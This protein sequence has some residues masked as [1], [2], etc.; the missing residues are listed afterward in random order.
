MR[1]YSHSYAEML[2]VNGTQISYSRVE[3]ATPGSGKVVYS[4]T[5]YDTNPD[6]TPGGNA[7]K[8]AP[9]FESTSSMFWE[10]GN[11]TSINVLNEN[12]I[13]SEELY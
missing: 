1:R 6:L 8:S 9:P 10:R 7:A 13:I 2:D 3:E 12:Q 5:N 4:F 11:L